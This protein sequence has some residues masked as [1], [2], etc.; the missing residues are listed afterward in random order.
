MRG[1]IERLGGQ[2]LGRVLPKAEAAAA[3]TI[4]DRWTYCQ[5]CIWDESWG[6]YR[7]AYRHEVREND[8][9]WYTDEPCG[10]WIGNWC[11]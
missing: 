7:P 3:C 8:C 9:R 4:D 2:L 5:Y 10:T 6:C 1:Q 11:C